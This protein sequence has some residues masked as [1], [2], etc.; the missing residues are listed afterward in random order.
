[1]A[2]PIGAWGFDE[3]TGTTAADATGNGHTLTRVNATW[4]ASGHTGA[5]LTNTATSNVGASGTVPA[6]TGTA[7]TL[8]AWVKPLNLAAGTTH[9]AVGI[10]QVN[11]NTDIALFTQRGD[12]GTSNVLQA[13]VRISG[14]LSSCNGT[15]AL[16]VGTW[17]HI[18]VTY[19][20]TSMRLYRNGV[21]ET[22]TSNAGTISTDTT[23]YVAGANANAALDTDVVV[24]DVRLYNAVLTQAEISAMKDTPV[25][26]GG[27]T[28]TGAGTSTLTLGASGSGQ[29]RT[30]AVRTSTLTLAAAGTGRKVVSSAGSAGLSLTKSGTGSKTTSA[31]RTA[32]LTLSS[33]G[34][35]R[36]TA[37]GSQPAVVVLSAAG[38]GS[39]AVSRTSSSVLVLSAAGPGSK[40]LTA[41][42]AAAL[43]LGGSGVASAVRSGA[44]TAVIL[45]GSSGSAPVVHSGAGTATL[46][47]HA[48]GFSPADVVPIALVPLLL[49]LP[50]RATAKVA[51]NLARASVAPNLARLEGART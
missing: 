36:K 47:L 18:A 29:K 37:V 45:L 42:S 38:T 40:V 2:T 49:I 20:G 43:A 4:D 23:I 17:A 7:I 33:S 44:A 16:T 1:M 11:G 28:F 13:D 51:L 19:D 41:A 48:S 35:G 15:S 26:A 3:G 34:T 32:S 24:D 27:T 10:F 6:V 39:K 46:V 21:L 14:G 5:A 25:S 8:M 9:A 31:A 30:T 50:N 22:T 12:F